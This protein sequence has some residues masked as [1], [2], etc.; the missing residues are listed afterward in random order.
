MPQQGLGVLSRCSKQDRQVCARKASRVDIG[1]KHPWGLGGKGAVWL[2]EQERGH[3]SHFHL[4]V[5]RLSSE[6]H[7]CL[8]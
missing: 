1:G 4:G 8:P 5:L 6:A 3:C 2:Q 7:S